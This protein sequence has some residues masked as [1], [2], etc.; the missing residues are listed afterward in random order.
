M[1]IYYDLKSI[2][3]DP[4][5]M[6]TVITSKF[7]EILYTKELIKQKYKN[8]DI[9]KYFNASKGRVYYMMQKKKYIPSENNTFSPISSF[10]RRTQY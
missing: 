9:M 7:Q 2:K 10:H 1:E 3:I 8:A 4:I 6:L 5:W